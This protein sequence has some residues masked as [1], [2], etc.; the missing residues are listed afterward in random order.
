MGAWIEIDELLKQKKINEVA[1]LVGAWIEILFFGGYS[2]DGARVAPLAGAWIEM[3]KSVICCN[4]K[5]APTLR[6]F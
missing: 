1:P 4:D 2:G 3:Q 5:L 6:S